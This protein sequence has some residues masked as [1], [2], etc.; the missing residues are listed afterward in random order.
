MLDRNFYHGSLKKLTIAFGDLFNNIQV[1]RYDSTGAEAQ[2]LLVPITYGPKEKWFARKQQDPEFEKKVQITLPR[3]GFEFVSMAY[4]ASR[5][6]SPTLKQTINEDTDNRK[7]LYTPVPW[8][9]TYNL[10]IVSR[11]TEDQSQI[12]EQ[13]L[14]FFTPTFVV[15]VAMIPEVEIID[16]IPFV[17]TSVS[18]A[19]DGEGDFDKL[20]YLVWNLQ[21]VAKARFYGPVSSQGVIKKAQVDTHIGSGD[22]EFTDAEIEATPRN[23][24]Y[25]VEPDPVTAT[26]E[27]DYGFSS[28]YEEF[29]D[30]KKYDPDTD[31]DVPV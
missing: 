22:Q 12:L 19:D 13:I 11:N 28:T 30:G 29:E 25:T 31:T 4:D 6:L 1:V 5:K 23:I 10:S 24:R 14:P 15:S 26:K 20:R 18:K 27:D 17:L 7:W 3:M 8:N 9:I 16:D 2:R 21:F